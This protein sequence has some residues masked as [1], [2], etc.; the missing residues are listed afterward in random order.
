MPV[1]NRSVWACRRGFSD[2]CYEKDAVIIVTGFL[3]TGKILFSFATGSSCT[4]PG[5]HGLMEEYFTS[6]FQ[7]VAAAPRTGYLLEDLLL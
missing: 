6:V 4:H 7:P 1:E 3:P 2:G 5:Q